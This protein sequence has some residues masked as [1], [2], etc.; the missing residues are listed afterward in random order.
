M[1]I[2]LDLIKCKVG[3]GLDQTEKK[4]HVKI[5]GSS[6]AQHIVRLNQAIYWIFFLV[7]SGRRPKI[8][9]LNS[10][11]ENHDSKTYLNNGVNNIHTFFKR[12]II[13]MFWDTKLQM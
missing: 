8:M 13:K 6:L 1:L 11:K 10:Q 7:G 9:T 12:Y 3:S 2:Q 5:F 4:C